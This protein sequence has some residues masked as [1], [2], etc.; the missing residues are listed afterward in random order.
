MKWWQVYG[1]NNE[2]LG[3]FTNRK[4]AEEFVFTKLDREKHDYYAIHHIVVDGVFLKKR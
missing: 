1:I 4:E 3:E 2:F